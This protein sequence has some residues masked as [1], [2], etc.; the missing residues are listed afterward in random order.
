MSVRNK[1]NYNRNKKYWKRKKNKKNLSVDTH[2][3][4]RFPQF[5][6]R[7]CSNL[8]YLKIPLN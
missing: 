3:Q 4:Y 6:V 2:I 1:T 8:A 7:Y 5:S